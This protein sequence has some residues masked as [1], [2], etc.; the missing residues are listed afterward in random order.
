MKIIKRLV[1]ILIFFI[2]MPFVC[3]FLFIQYI[4]T[5]DMDD[6]FLEE[7]GEWINS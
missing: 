3:I 2:F 1:G 5:G 4:I 6:R 7:Y